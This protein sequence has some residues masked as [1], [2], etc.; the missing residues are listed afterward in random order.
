MFCVL[1][2]TSFK[3][4]IASLREI[5]D[6]HNLTNDQLIAI[7]NNSGWFISLIAEFIE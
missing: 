2:N 5:V 1:A 6:D 7:T 4:Y 3:A